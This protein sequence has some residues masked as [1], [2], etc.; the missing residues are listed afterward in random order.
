[1]SSI[2]G[3]LYTKLLALAIT[4]RIYDEELPQNPTYPATVYDLIDEVGIGRNHDGAAPFREARVQIDV[5]ALSGYQAD[6][7]IE[8]YFDA[9]QSFDDTLGDG[10]SPETQYPVS[11]RYENTN[12]NQSFKDEKTLQN[13][14][15]R[16]MDF[17][18][19]YK[20]L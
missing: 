18:V 15:G 1:V 16:S 7:L 8:Q 5:F 9:L 12:P 20:P 10:Q 13:V 19:L 11:I 17:K 4:P 6:T 3:A 2:K 14:R